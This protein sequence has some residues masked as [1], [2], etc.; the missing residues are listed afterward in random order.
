MKGLYWLYLVLM[1]GA[2]F[3]AYQLYAG[4]QSIAE[5]ASRCLRLQEP[6]QDKCFRGLAYRA[7]KLGSVIKTLSGDN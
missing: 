7:E 4:Q 3:L 2:L 1:L 5:E 6:E